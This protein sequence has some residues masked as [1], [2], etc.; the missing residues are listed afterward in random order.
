[1]FEFEPG[2]WLIVLAVGVFFLT[3]VVIVASSL[4]GEEEPS[5]VSPLANR[6]RDESGAMRG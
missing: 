6:V 2:Y 4:M 3:A 5:L 1:M